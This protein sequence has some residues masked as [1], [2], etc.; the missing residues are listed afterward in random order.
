VSLQT[1]ADVKSCCAAAYSSPAA[2][3]LL[4]ESLHPGGAALT[5]RLADAVQLRSGQRVL[6]VASGRGATA[7][8]LAREYAVAVDGVDLSDASVREATAAAQR[9][10]RAAMVAFQLADAEHLPFEDGTFDA[11]V[12]ECSWCLFPDKAQAAAEFARVLRRGGRLG[13]ADVSVGRAG[14]PDGLAELPAW[15][16]CLA[17]ARTTDEYVCLLTAAGLTATRVEDH[18][19][20]LAALVDRIQARLKLARALSESGA[21]LETE[22]VER[23]LVLAARAAEAVSQGALGYCL[24]VAQRDR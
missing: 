22:A 19:D 9:A 5:R 1:A 13:I 12:C 14:V 17:G 24:V 10:G 6:D 23:G 8:L 21:Q 20:A 16:A 4:G 2:A 7:L 11:L 15:I 3:F 18:S